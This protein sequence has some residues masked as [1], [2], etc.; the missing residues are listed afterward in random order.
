MR[1]VSMFFTPQI[2]TRLNLNFFSL[3]R[4]DGAPLNVRAEIGREEQTLRVVRAQDDNHWQEYRWRVDDR[5]RVEEF[6]DLS[7]N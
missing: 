2:A 7:N 6:F 4:E 1:T 5:G 3:T